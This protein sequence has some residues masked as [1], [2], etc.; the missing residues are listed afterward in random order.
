M[1]HGNINEKNLEATHT[2]IDEL[3][4]EIRIQGYADIAEI[5]YI[6]FEPCGKLSLIPF[7]LDRNLT[8]R[9]LSVGVDMRGIS[10]AVI[11]NGEINEDALSAAG[12]SVVWL[13][14][15]LKRSDT[16]L[17]DILYM[18]VDD[19]GASKVKLKNKERK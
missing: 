4:S 12:R 18:T 1:A 11:T 5:E 19:K 7:P 13:K 2:T 8:P 17:E 9:D 10:H 15:K 14:N 3:F 6:I 16:K